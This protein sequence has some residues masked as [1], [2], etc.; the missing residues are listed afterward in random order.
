MRSSSSYQVTENTPSEPGTYLRWHEDQKRLV[1][2]MTRTTLHSN[3]R[4]LVV[5]KIP[6]IL[7][8]ISS[9]H[10]SIYDL[11]IRQPIM[12]FKDDDVSN[13]QVRHEEWLMKCRNNPRDNPAP[14][15]L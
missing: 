10:N 15:R 1:K 2:Q 3:D 7:R 12:E 4:P 11:P 6:C 5:L 14:K 13:S 8:F 9:D